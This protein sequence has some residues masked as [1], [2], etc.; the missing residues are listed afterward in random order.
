MLRSY[1]AIDNILYLSKKS[2]PQ[3]IKGLVQ[4]YKTKDITSW[5]QGQLLFFGKRN[6]FCHVTG[7]LLA[8]TV[9]KILKKQ[10]PKTR[11]QIHYLNKNK[12]I[13]KIKKI[14]QV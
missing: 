6:E 14:K 10:F 8:W 5:D 13:L 2:T 12:N 9:R 7:N 11:F 1:C 4:K 3:L